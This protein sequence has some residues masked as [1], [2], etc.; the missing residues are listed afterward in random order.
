MIIQNPTLKENLENLA[1]VSVCIAVAVNV[2]KKIMK[3]VQKNKSC[4]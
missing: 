2:V 4:K 3:E 1:T